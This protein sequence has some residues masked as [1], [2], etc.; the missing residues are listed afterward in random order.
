MRS[1]T[2]VKEQIDGLKAILA[3]P[4][5]RRMTFFDESNTE[6]IEAQIET[7]EERYSVDTVDNRDGEEWTEHAA[8]SARDAA[9]WLAGESDDDPVTGW[10]GLH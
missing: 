3:K 2:V 4:T 9:Y 5:F 7:L 1:T 6:A 10:N 8:S